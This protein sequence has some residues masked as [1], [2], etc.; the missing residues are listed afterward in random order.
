MRERD[1]YLHKLGDYLSATNRSRLNDAI[2]AAV[3][4]KSAKY[5]TQ[6]CFSP[7][8]LVRNTTWNYFIDDGIKERVIAER[9]TVFEAKN[10]QNHAEKECFQL[11]ILDDW[12]R[13]SA[14]SFI[15]ERHDEDA[16]MQ[17]EV[18][19]WKS[20]DLADDKIGDWMK[21]ALWRWSGVCLRNSS[22]LC[23]PINRKQNTHPTNDCA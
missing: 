12:L 7:A 1:D 16:M 23:S 14:I 21:R 10:C 22:I 4:G 9:K 3:N 19:K 18:I 17:I 13:S 8:N 11:D 20:G 6:A 5:S 15:R 2:F